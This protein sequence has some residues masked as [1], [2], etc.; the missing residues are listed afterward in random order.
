[1]SSS[2]ILLLDTHIWIWWVEQDQRLPMVLK[3]KVS[4]HEGVLAISAATIYETITLVRK[5]RIALNRSTDD[6]IDRATRWAD[7]EVIPLDASIAL[8]AGNLPFHHSDPID[9]LIIASAVCQNALLISM[10]GQFPLYEAL[11]G[12]LISNKD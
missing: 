7:I 6:W 10:D 3:N 1:M 2:S 9:R 11:V 8:Q 12:R 5:N 4:E